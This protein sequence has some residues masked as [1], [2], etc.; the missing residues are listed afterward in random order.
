MG[1][2]DD[3]DNKVALTHL[4]QTLHID[5]CSASADPLGTR[6]RGVIRMCRLETVDLE[7]NNSASACVLLLLLEL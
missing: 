4:S 1:G 7:R 3:D 6:D 2:K 5:F